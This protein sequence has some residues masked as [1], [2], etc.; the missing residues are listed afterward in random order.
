[1]FCLPKTAWPPT[2]ASRVVDTVL[3]Q[4]PHFGAGA[5][6]GERVM[7]EYAQPNTH[8]SFHIGHVRTALLGESLARIMQFAGFETI[9]A[10]YPG[11]VG[12]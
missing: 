12:L 3:T 9:R 1:M 10:S 4:G 8:H 11:D 2:Y 5:P 7:V 6:K